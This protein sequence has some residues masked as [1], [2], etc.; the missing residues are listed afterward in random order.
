MQHD[1]EMKT[2]GRLKN[3]MYGFIL[4]CI[5]MYGMEKSILAKTLSAFIGNEVV[6]VLTVNSEIFGR[7]LFS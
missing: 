4:F 5:N 6:N 7:V 1:L 2:C 3:I